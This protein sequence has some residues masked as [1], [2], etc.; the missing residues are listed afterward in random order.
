MFISKLVY[1]L[2]V[3]VDYFVVSSYNMITRSDL[4]IHTQWNRRH[5]NASC[6][7]TR[8]TQRSCRLVDVKFS[9]QIRISFDIVESSTH[10]R[11]YARIVC[12]VCGAFV[13]LNI[14]CTSAQETEKCALN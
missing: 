8:A 5:G 1:R 9:S 14:V 2:A 3:V 7:V 12:S 13:T 6:A 4:D 10:A 11:T